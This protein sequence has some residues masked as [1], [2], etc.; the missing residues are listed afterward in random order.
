MDELLLDVVSNS[1][2]DVEELDDE[3]DVVCPIVL[4]VDD[5]LDVVCASV[6]DVLDDV[7]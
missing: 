1:V 3:L 6:L 2:D 7:V 4:D 5:E